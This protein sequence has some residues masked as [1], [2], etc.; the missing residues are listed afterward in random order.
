MP[1]YDILI[2][3][4]GAVKIEKS[5]GSEPAKP[6]SD[7]QLEYEQ[8]FLETMGHPMPT[9]EDPHVKLTDA[10]Q[11]HLDALVERCGA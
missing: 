9:P 3:Q 7:A 11:S 5:R 4:Y 1:G 8:H 2:A 6:K 10:E